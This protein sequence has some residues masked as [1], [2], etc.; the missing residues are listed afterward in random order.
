[1]RELAI[2]GVELLAWGDDNGGKVV[3]GLPKKIE[4]SINDNIKSNNLKKAQ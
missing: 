2:P 3:S 1:M 4:P